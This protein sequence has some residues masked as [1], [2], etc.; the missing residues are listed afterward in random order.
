MQETIPSPDGE[1]AEFAGFNLEEITQLAT[2][3]EISKGFSLGFAE[4]N[5]AADL[6]LLLQSLKGH[7]RCRDVQFVVIK[8]D[9][10]ELEFVLSGI[11]EELAKVTL[12]PDK[13]PVLLVI[14]LERAIGYVNTGKTPGVIANLNFARNLFPKQLPYPIIFFLPDYALTRL[15]RG[16]HD[17]WAWT[18]A[19]FQFRS[20]RQRVTQTYQKTLSEQRMFT[21]DDKPVKQERID[22]LQ[23][24]LMQYAPTTGDVEAETAPLRLNILEELADTYLSLSD[25]QHARN[26]YSQ[27]FA[28]A[29]DLDNQWTQA[30]I[31]LGLGKTATLLETSQEA[32][33][34]YNEALELYKATGD[35]TGEANTLQLIG[36]V[37]Q[38]LKQSQEALNHY[39][40]A[41][42]LYKD[43]GDRLGE[44]NTLKAIGDVLQ[45]LKQSQEALNRYQ[46]ALGLYKDVGARL[47]EANTLRAIG[48][49][50]QFLDQRQEALNHYQ[51]ALGL[52][53]DVGDRLG[54][55]NTL[56]AIG[57][58]LQFLK[59]SQ[60]ALNHYQ[61]ALK[62]YRDVGDR[63]GEANTLQAIGD[64]LQF[65]KQSQEAL[66]RYQEA[67]GLYKDVGDRLGEANT[68]QAIGDVLLRKEDLDE[69]SF[70]QSCEYL[71]TAYSLYCDIGD[72]YS[73][74]RILLTSI[75]PLQ[76]RQ[77]ET[78]QA[79]VSAQEAADIAA[80]IG[81]EPMQQH[82]DRILTELTQP[83]TP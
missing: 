42:G 52:Y 33:N 78:E 47:G 74:A 32:L 36:D 58:V 66:N 80:A 2:F 19:S 61:E 18:S 8:L 6:E 75:I 67:L 21:S 64:V 28:L 27:A 22:R 41:L 79:I 35:G 48:D 63:L 45:F 37:L 46:E 25:V 72:R 15:A 49:V 73:Q 60:E 44:A 40:E 4:L 13:K 77:G 68:L 29:K 71:N 12:D 31:L 14:G 55:A 7:R 57:D 30:N 81:Y 82:A 34:Y 5:F 26:Y 59:Q 20:S 43:V 54:E 39:Q 69:E 23:R 1:S 70:N 51:E 24:L 10:P 9:D 16:A 11:K 17:F 65:L 3:A 76:I 50:L 38:F 83:T 53:K 56:Q 62:L